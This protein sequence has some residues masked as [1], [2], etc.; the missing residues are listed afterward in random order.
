M[1]KVKTQIL[2]KKQIIIA[3]KR[4][5]LEFAI[6]SLG[7]FFIPFLLAHPQMLVGVAVNI[8][9]IRAALVLKNN[10]IWP[11]IFLPSLGVI[12]RG[13]LFS[14]LTP[15]LLYLLPFIFLGNFIL[16][17]FV[18]K[19]QNSNIIEKFLNPALFKAMFIA[20]GAFLF[21]KLAIV[22][23]MLLS[24]MSLWQFINAFVAL[25][26]VYGVV[27]LENFWQSRTSKS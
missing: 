19:S 27:S 1:E 9:L 26:I 17:Y 5:W 24:A 22:P 18:K 14:S 11:I 20:A 12:S 10:K 15:F 23:A 6:I 21:I 8:L 4:Q 13:L 2:I 7:S 25:L 3:D 16:V